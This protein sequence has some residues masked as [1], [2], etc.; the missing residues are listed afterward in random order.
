MGV[1]GGMGGG[2][3]GGA[4]IS[5]IGTDSKVYS[6]SGTENIIMNENTIIKNI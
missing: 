4:C 2:E 1:K 5:V 3:G 6:R